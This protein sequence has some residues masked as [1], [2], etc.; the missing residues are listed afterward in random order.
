MI[1][2]TCGARGHSGRTTTTSAKCGKQAQGGRS[3]R[4]WMLASLL[5]GSDGYQWRS[6]DR[7]SSRRFH[8]VT[9]I[10][11]QSNPLGESQA[12]QACDGRPVLLRFG[13]DSVPQLPALAVSPFE[14]GGGQ[15]LGLRRWPDR[16][17]QRSSFLTG[18]S[19]T[20]SPC[21]VLRT[22]STP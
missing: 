8:R 16:V 13:T 3:M 9:A 7:A 22:R 21:L 4:I 17:G 10:S 2:S 14:T 1:A 19:R 12:P 5:Y 15:A 20:G 11:P 6:R 18:C